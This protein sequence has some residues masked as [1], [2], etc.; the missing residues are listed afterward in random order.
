MIVG[1]LVAAGLVGLW[2]WLERVRR[3]GDAAD[4]VTGANQT[5]DSVDDLPRSPDFVLTPGLDLRGLGTVPAPQPASTGG[6]D[7][8]EA[9]NFKLA[10]V[11]AYTSVQV[12]RAAGVK[13]DLIPLDL[14]GVVDATLVAIDPKV[15]IPRYVLGTILLPAH[16]I[17]LIGETFTEAMAYPELDIPMYK[18]LVD[19]STEL[20]VPNLHLIEQNTVTL[21][22]TN[23]RF[24]ESYMVGLNHEFARELL[25]R[26]YPTDQRGSYFRQFWDVSTF[27]DA[28]PTDDEATARGAARTSRRCTCGRSSPSSATTTTASK[29][30]RTRR[31]SCS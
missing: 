6:T 23:Q 12:G 1:A 21:L 31:S 3:A 11:D 10:L 15:T 26:E 16:I 28:R 9:R 8:V 7:S 25:W 18:P 24:I 27:L 22:N 19:R 2:W 30:S 13:P 17:G 20:F 5:P 4:S 14:H 29:G